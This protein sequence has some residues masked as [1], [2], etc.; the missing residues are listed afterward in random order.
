M[1]AWGGG[2]G[3]G[4]GV[5]FLVSAALTYDVVSATNSSPQTTELNASTRARTLMKWVHIGLGQALLFI[6]AAAYFDRRHARPIL[7]GGLLA[8]VLMEIQYLH[9]RSAGLKNKGP[10]TESYPAG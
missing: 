8:L 7:A 6:L 1:Q 10:A 2:D 4:F 3:V 5:A 9:A